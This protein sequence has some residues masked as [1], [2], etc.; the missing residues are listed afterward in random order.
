MI[1]NIVCVGHLENIGSVSF[2]DLPKNDS[3]LIQY[4]TL[5]F[6]NITADIIR[7]V[8]KVLQSCQVHGDGHKI[9]KI[10]IFTWKLC[11][12]SWQPALSIVFLEMTVSLYS[13]SRTNLPNT[14]S[15]SLWLVIFPV[16]RIFHRGWGQKALILC[17]VQATAGVLFSKTTVTRQYTAEV[18]YVY[19]PFCYTKY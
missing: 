15:E 19:F 10:L 2:A 1:L 6:I 16:T 18:F 11:A 17:A 5:T 8:L 4:K 13:F 9:S 14:K 7:E 12:L 3:F